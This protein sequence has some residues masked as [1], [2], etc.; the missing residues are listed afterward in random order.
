MVN[1]I[2]P[3]I[4][5]KRSTRD[6][7]LLFIVDYSLWGTSDFNMMSVAM[8]TRVEYNSESHFI[9]HNFA[10]V[11]TPP[12]KQSRNSTVFE[13]THTLDPIAFMSLHQVIFYIYKCWILN[14]RLGWPNSWN[15]R[16][17]L[18]NKWKKRMVTFLT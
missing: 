12:C 17:N 6:F 7:L 18:W 14:Q 3:V 8:K 4:T 1:V 13:W 5:I 2:A 11:K 16:F 15:S 9:S 10:S